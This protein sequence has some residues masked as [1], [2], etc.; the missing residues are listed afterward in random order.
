MTRIFLLGCGTPTPSPGRFGS[1]YIVQTGDDYLMFDCGPATTHKLV[2]T[3]LC[4]TQISHL[5]FTHH[6]FDHDVDYPC[7]L[8][9]RWDQSIGKENELQVFGPPPTEEMTDGLIGQTGVFSPDWKARI[10]QP[11]SQAGNVGRRGTAQARR[12]PSV[13]ARNVG[14]GTVCSGGGWEVIAAPTQHTAPLLE[15]LA[16]RINT[17]DEVIVISGDT[18]I[19]QSVIDLAQNADTLLMMCM[20]HQEELGDDDA[21]SVGTGTT[22]AA[23]I[24]QEAGVKKLVLVHQSAG[25]DTPASRER[26]LRN[27]GHIYRGTLVWGEELMEVP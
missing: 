8:L 21:G 17:P 13:S 14:S 22:N 26:A 2:K 1:S 23:R 19:C 25:L 16:Y 27:I 9:T 5:F 4:P 24:A 7:F 11:W 6:H 3:G 18:G 15:S 10:A 12:P 20:F